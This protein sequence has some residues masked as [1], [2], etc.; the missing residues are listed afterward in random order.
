M[1]ESKDSLFDR[2]VRLA[3]D[4]CRLNGVEMPKLT[5]AIG[6]WPY[7]AC[8]YYRPTTGI[9]IAVSKCAG[10]GMGGPAWSFPGYTVDRTPYGV[11]AHELGHHC[12]ATR[13]DRHAPGKYWSDY[14]LSVLTASREAPLTGYLGTGDAGAEAAEWFAEMFRLFVTNPD[15][16]RA[17]RPATHARLIADGWRPVFSDGWEARLADAPAR[18]IAQARKKVA[19]AA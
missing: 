3:Q 14:S 13:C 10:I 11:I 8:A 2:G 17:I 18:T 19:A 7:A 15:L 4:F 16:L 9:H 5:R 12:D 6:V 1:V